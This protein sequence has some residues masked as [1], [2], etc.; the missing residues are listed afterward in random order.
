MLEPV[1]EQLASEGDGGG[2]RLKSVLER[3]QG[4]VAGGGGGDAPA[5]GDDQGVVAPFTGAEG[6]ADEGAVGPDQPLAAAPDPLAEHGRGIFIVRAVT[7]A[8]ET[9]RDGRRTTVRAVK[10]AVVALT[11]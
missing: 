3:R 6:D 5:Q 7:D 9:R 4:A 8:L 1:G 2:Q 10:R 11:D